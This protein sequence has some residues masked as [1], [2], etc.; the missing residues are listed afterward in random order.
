MAS[1][2]CIL[3]KLKLRSFLEILNIFLGS[4]VISWIRDRSFYYVCVI[5]L[6]FSNSFEKWEKSS[7]AYMRIVKFY[8]KSP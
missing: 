4:F 6:G 8:L 1:S 3:S 5:V 7:A 2:F